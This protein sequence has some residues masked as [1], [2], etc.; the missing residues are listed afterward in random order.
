MKERKEVEVRIDSIAF[1]GIA[2]GR[3]D[4]KV[5]FI[6]NAVPGDKVIAYINKSKKNYAEGKVKEY[7]EL[8]TDRTEPKCEYFGECGGCSWQ[9]LDYNHQLYWKNKNVIDAFERIGN[10]K[11]LNIN[12][13]IGSNQI[14]YYRNKMEFSFGANRWLRDNEIENKD[15]IIDKDFALGLH[16]S[17]RFDKILD[18]N[19][20]E[21]QN[22]YANE[23]L[24]F[25]KRQAL[26]NSISAYN[27][28]EH[29]GFLRSLIIRHSLFED[30]FLLILVSNEVSNKNEQEFLDN[31]S[32]ELKVN[33]SKIKSLIFAINNGKN[34]VNINSFEV[35]FGDGYLYEEILGITFKISPFSFFQ[36]NSYQLNS[37]IGKIIE[38]ADVKNEDIVWDLFCGTGSITL[39]LAK[40]CKFI[41]G[42]EFS[43]FSVRD[44]YQN[45]DL[46]NITNSEFLSL[47]LNKKESI[48]KLKNIQTPDVV[49][50]DPPRA[51]LSKHLID[52]LNFMKIKKIVYVSCN[53]ATQARDCNLLSENY[54]LEKLQPF[55][56]FPH[57][58]H[59]ENI[60]LLKL[61][62]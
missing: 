22:K 3:V 12:D 43:E 36:T 4:G 23:I 8:S 15:K 21:I 38:L 46:N 16:I 14:Y 18:I 13:I 40:K 45:R 11:N 6:K 62:E 48:Y 25:I 2:I 30:N 35:I 17:G 26:K 28:K 52:F 32:I 55:D 58:F 44:A 53:P 10:F 54:I 59:I 37:F 1:E 24:K 19:N 41:Y 34:P 33:F 51:G 39:P 57:T 31:L 61:K 50:L 5:Y 9:N 7:I 49:I 47:D 29:K 27:L 56:M 42:I 20:C 60:A